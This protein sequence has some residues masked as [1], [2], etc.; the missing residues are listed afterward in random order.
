MDRFIELVV[1][2]TAAARLYGAYVTRVLSGRLKSMH[3]VCKVR[4]LELKYV[5]GNLSQKMALVTCIIF[6]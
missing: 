4:R 6:R 1:Q 2:C 5:T 3:R